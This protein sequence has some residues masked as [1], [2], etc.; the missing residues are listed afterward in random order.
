MVSAGA[1]FMVIEASSHALYQ[2]R[3][4][5]ITFKAAAFTNLTGDHL[6]YHKTEARY[7]SAKSLLFEKLSPDATAVLNADSIHSCLI[8]K[9]TKA[10]TLFFAIDKPAA[11]KA[12]VKS[13]NIQGSV[14]EIEYAGQKQEVT[15]PLLGKYNVS[16]CL[17][18]AGLCVAAGFDLKSIAKGIAALQ[19]VPGRMEKVDTD[20]DFTVLIDYAHTDDALKN[21]LSTL[22]DLCEG[23]L[24]VVFGCGGDRDKTKRPRMARVAENLA[25]IVIV[26][27]DN[28]RTEEPAAII[29]EI[30]ASFKYPTA[31]KISFELQRKNAIELAIKKAGKGDI[32]LLAGKGHEDYQIIGNKKI[33]FSDKEVASDC[34][35]RLK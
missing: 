27:S 18:A 10:K 14:F 23:K 1:K 32:V 22:R 6:D 30:A 13:I 17:A 28:P 21:V 9:K 19:T 16:N 25:D 31:D 24:I 15:T 11:L 4:A 3:L 26:T 33:P 8:A 12:D 35:K 7:L 2:N 20:A 34:L 5:A 29:G